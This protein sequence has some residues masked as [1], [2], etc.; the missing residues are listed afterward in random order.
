MSTAAPAGPARYSPMIKRLLLLSAMLYLQAF[1]NCSIYRRR[2]FA[3]GFRQK[4]SE[5]CNMQRASVQ[6]MSRMTMS[7]SLCGYSTFAHFEAAQRL[8]PEPMQRD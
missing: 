1:C 7:G 4:L 2:L 5:N 6:H 3:A 8:P